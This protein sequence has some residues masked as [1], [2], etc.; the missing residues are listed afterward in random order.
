MRLRFTIR[1]LLWLTLVVAA[2]TGVFIFVVA[3]VGGPPSVNFHPIAFDA[4][5]WK[6]SPSEFSHNS[7]RLR[8]VDDFLERESPIGKSR[9]KIVALLGEP[10]DTPYFRN[11]DMVYRLGQERH[12]FGIDS[13]WL[14]FR[15]DKQALVTE[16]TLVR[17]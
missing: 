6:A 8:M 10:D 16:A 14:V 2:M 4:T 12:P 15:L 3:R 1:D 11:Y 17:D 5:T 9:E 13:E 7:I